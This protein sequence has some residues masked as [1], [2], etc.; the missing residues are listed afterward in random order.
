MQTTLIY[1]SHFKDLSIINPKDLLNN[2][3][4]QVNIKSIQELQQLPSSN[5]H[6]GSKQKSN[7][8][9]LRVEK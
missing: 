4:F 2:F 8:G 6:N 5:S 7:E 9:E 1:S 3:T